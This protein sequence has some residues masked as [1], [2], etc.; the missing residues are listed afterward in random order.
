MAGLGI[1][2]LIFV[3]ALLFVGMVGVAFVILRK[4]DPE[5]LDSTSSGKMETAQ[6]FLPFVDIRDQ[7]IHMGNNTYHAVVEVS[8]VNYA[9]RND[10]EKDIIELTFQNFLNSLTFPVTLYISTRAMDYTKLVESMKVDYEKTYTDFPKMREYLQQNLIDMQNLSQSLGETRH[11][12]KYIIIPYDANILS[13]LDSDEKYEATKEVLL[14]RVKGVQNGMERIAGLNTKL[15]DTFEIIDL[16]IQTYH[17]DGSTFAEEL[18]NGVLTSTIVG[19]DQVVKP[20]NFSGEELYDV[21]LNEMQST[22]ETRFIHNS[23]IDTETKL[24]AEKLWKRIHEVRQ[25]DDLDGLK[26]NHEKERAKE[27]QRKIKNGEVTLYGTDSGYNDITETE[28]GSGRE[29]L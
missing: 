18:Q 1:F 19:G 5:R 20:S 6:D 24:K 9:L 11:K 28:E 14:E 23:S 12:K 15:L 29:I 8:S 25:S 10:R 13:E 3:V 26:Y 16:F 22:L 2:L 27:F 21:M 4:N 17:R 7:M